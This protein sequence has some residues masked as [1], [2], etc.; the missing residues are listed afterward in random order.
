MLAEGKASDC[1]RM[2][3][4]Y[5]SQLDALSPSEDP[6]V[7]NDLLL[8]IRKLDNTLRRVMLDAK[9]FAVKERR[10]AELKRLQHH[11]ATT[12]ALVRSRYSS[13]PVSGVAFLTRDG[14]AAMGD[15]EMA[16]DDG[17][18]PLERYDIHQDVEFAQFFAE[19]K[20]RD[21]SIE[22]HLDRI[23]EGV[24]R[25]SENAHGIQDELQVQSEVMKD[26]D[27]KVE[28]N[29][30]RLT[31]MNKRMRKAIKKLGKSRLITYGV[32]CLILT[33]LIIVIGF[34]AKAL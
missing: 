32:M 11:C 22:A 18:A 28:E 16:A 7:R 1:M 10:A 21:A 20:E 13:S 5:T 19:T 14:E 30:G 15:D 4:E 34:L 33:V 17:G 9:R 27:G 8:N 31:S 25:V 26:T 2:I 24:L 29:Q 3:R 12:Q 23:H 6:A